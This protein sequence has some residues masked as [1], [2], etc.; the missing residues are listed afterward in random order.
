ML[1][2]LGTFFHKTGFRFPRSKLSL[3][4]AIVFFT[5]FQKKDASKVDRGAVFPYMPVVKFD[6]ADYCSSLPKNC[7][8]LIKQLALPE[9]EVLLVGKPTS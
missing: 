5:Q 3:K 1:F 9:R 4:S 6:P 7:D 8:I 2:I